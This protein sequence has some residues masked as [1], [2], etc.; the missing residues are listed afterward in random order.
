LAVGE[1]QSRT[2]VGTAIAIQLLLLGLLLGGGESLMKPPHR[3][4][5]ARTVGTPSWIPGG[6]AAEAG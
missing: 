5:A 6:L 4:R 2:P 1:D 3:S